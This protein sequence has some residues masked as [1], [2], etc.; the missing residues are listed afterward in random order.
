MALGLIMISFIVLC[1]MGGVGMIFLF[2]VK[3]PAKKKWILYYMALL[4]M[5]VAALQAFSLPSNYILQQLL[6][7]AIVFLSVAA[8]LIY[9]TKCPA[10][11]WLPSV[12]VSTSVIVG[13]FNHFF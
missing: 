7:W 11:K 5:A 8:V 3:D 1:T 9:V 10:P 6:S 13:I 12:L 2:C 4:G